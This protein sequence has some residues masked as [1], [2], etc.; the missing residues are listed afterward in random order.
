MIKK[1]LLSMIALFIPALVMGKEADHSVG[2]ANVAQNLME[3]VGVVADFVQTG[4]LVI[5]GAFIFTSI[6]R[7]IE[8][9]RSPLMTP[10]STVVFLFIAGI[11]LIL[12]PFL[13]Y[14]VDSGI[15]YSFLK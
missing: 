2:L 1:L 10:I 7:Y 15:Q 11:L 3:P 8:H 9:R 5:G 14:M 12:L 4:C 6:I 13:S